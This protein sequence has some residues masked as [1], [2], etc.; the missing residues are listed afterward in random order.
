MTELEFTG[1]GNKVQERQTREAW[2]H[3]G[4]GVPFRG[5]PLGIRE[6]L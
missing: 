2:L 1:W 5:S 6:R 4:G 3:G